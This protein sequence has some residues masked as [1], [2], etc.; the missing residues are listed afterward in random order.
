MNNGEV[1]EYEMILPLQLHILLAAAVLH[2]LLPQ[3]AAHHNHIHHPDL[4][5]TSRKIRR[6]F[7]D[8]EIRRLT[9]PYDMGTWL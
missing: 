3:E 9:W 8:R 1:S 2:I 5:H 6:L 7:D 4:L